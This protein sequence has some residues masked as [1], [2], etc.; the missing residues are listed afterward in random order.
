MGIFDPVGDFLWGEWG[1]FGTKFWSDHRKNGFNN[2]YHV[3]MS[4]TLKM[5]QAA[6]SQLLSLMETK[7]SEGKITVTQ[8]NAI[9]RQRNKLYADARLAAPTTSYK[10]VP[11]PPTIKDGLGNMV[12]D[13]KEAGKNVVGSVGEAAGQAV[14]GVVNSVFGINPAYIMVA[15]MIMVG[16]NVLNGFKSFFR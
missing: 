15:V 10:P 7:L 12:D 2:E 9:L 4:L 14:T 6:P 1:I 16:I 11:P 13:F 3:F 8:Y 5:W